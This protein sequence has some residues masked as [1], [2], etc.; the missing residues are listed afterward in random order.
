MSLTGRRKYKRSKEEE[1]LIIICNT[2]VTTLNAER[3]QKT[4]PSAGEFHFASNE[5]ENTTRYKERRITTRIHKRK[6]SCRCVPI[7]ICLMN[8]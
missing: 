5:T 4:S 1:N 2:K 3:K 7:K 6:M 8:N